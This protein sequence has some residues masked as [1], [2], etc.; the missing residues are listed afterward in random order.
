MVADVDII[1]ARAIITLITFEFDHL[2]TLG[3]DQEPFH[4]QLGQSWFADVMVLYFQTSII[5][6]KTQ[7]DTKANRL[8]LWQ[9]LQNTCFLKQHTSTPDLRKI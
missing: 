3:P 2:R 1:F 6:F 9:L 8:E 5:F 4:L 7:G